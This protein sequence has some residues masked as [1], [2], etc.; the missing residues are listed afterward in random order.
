MKVATWV[1]AFAPF[2]LSNVFAVPLA[3]PSALDADIAYNKPAKEAR[4]SALDADIAYNKPAKEARVYAIFD[5]DA[6]SSFPHPTCRDRP[7]RCY[8]IIEAFDSTLPYLESIGSGE[9]WGSAPFS[10]K[11]GFA[12]ETQQQVRQSTTYDFTGQGEAIRVLIAETLTADKPRNILDMSRHCR[13]YHG[14]TD[15]RWIL[16]VGAMVLRDGWMPDYLISQAH[17]DLTSA[18]DDG[19]VYIEVMVTDHRAGET[20]KGAGRA[21]IQAAIEYAKQ[22]GKKR[23]YVDGWAGNERKLIEYYARNG[24]SVVG[25]YQLE[26]AKG[27]TWTGTLLM[28]DV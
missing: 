2:L 7:L 8:F 20:R 12:A 14:Y 16:P 28:M 15:S 19:F 21:L 13:Y 24:F 1:L 25:D 9:Q 17:L 22:K 26:R 27:A 4:D 23:V 5:H 10:Q 11:A 18:A 6:P 3:A